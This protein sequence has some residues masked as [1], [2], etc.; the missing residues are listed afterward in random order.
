VND[1][2]AVLRTYLLTKTALTLLVGTRINRETGVPAQGWTPSAGPCVSI[3]GRG[4]AFD[5]SD[6]MLAWPV[7]VTC[8]GRD[9]QEAG[10]VYRAVVGALDNASG[11]QLRHAYLTSLGQTIRQ[12]ET[13]WPYV[14]C[15]FRVLISKE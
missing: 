6:A 9:P 14:L 1:A 10:N 5:A 4:G 7:Q 13:G 12:A 3:I 15:G 8:W 11:G 2:S